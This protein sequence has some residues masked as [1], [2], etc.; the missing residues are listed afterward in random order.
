MDPAVGTLIFLGLSALFAG[1]IDAIAGG[2]GLVQLPALLTGLP[3]QSVAEVLGTNKVASILGTSSATVTYARRARPDFATA[4][5]MALAA[6]GG[7]ALGASVASALPPT[8]FRP[9]IVVL[10]AVVGVYTW[11]RPELGQI[12]RLRFGR[13]RQRWIAAGV[14]SIIGF[15]DGLIGPGTG[16]FLVFALVGL[17]GYA[18]LHASATAKI[19]NVGTNAAA[20]MVFGYN[21]TVLWILGLTLGICNVIGALIGV[22]LALRGGSNL[23]RRVFLVVVVALLAKVGWDVVRD[24]LL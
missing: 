7:S 15:Y 14:G 19:V 24:L 5:P 23:V 17:L 20:I 2:G 8:I 9:I 16:S 10:L 12:E 22:R 13:R 6:F 21:G 4:L 3:R 18:F 11:R 1:C